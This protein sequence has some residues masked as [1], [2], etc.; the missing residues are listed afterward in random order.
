MISTVDY[1]APQASLTHPRTVDVR[2]KRLGTTRPAASSVVVHRLLPPGAHVEV[3]ATAVV[4]AGREEAQVAGWERS[5]ARLGSVPA[6]KKGGLVYLSG[7]ASIDH[8]TGESVVADY[9]IADQGRKA[10]QNLAEACAA[11]GVD[12]TDIA[13]TVEYLPPSAIGDYRKVQQ[14]RREL[15]GNHFP[16]AAGISM[17][18]LSRPELLIQISAIA[19]A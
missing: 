12:I 8:T 13:Y 18:Q 16:A 10:Y 17:Y 15:F 9:D 6:A 2:R 3:E 7:Q 19:L 14:V 4:G 11:A 5:Y 1:V